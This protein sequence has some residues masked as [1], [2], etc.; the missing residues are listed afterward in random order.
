MLHDFTIP[1][2]TIEYKGSPV[3]DVRGLSFND[4]SYLILQHRDDVDKLVTLWDAYSQRGG[5]SEMKEAVI[6]QYG[7]ELLR[8]APG[9]AADAHESF[10]RIAKLPSSVQIDALKAIGN[11]TIEDFGGA[12]K[13]LETLW[14]TVL[15]HAPDQVRNS[16]EPEVQ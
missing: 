7:F 12:K 6:I 9:M 5:F 2:K 10:A 8:E 15:A 1:T 3:L 4:I 16:V 14:T 11:M 13:M